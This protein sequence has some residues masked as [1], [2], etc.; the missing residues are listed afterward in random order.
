M[1][2]VTIQCINIYVILLWLMIS[3]RLWFSCVNFKPVFYCGQ[4]PICGFDLN[5]FA[6]Q[7]F[8]LQMNSISSSTVSILLFHKSLYSFVVECK[9][10][11]NYSTLSVLLDT[12]HVSMT[13]YLCCDR[14][15]SFNLR[16]E[17]GPPLF[18]LH[19]MVYV[20]LE[21]ETNREI[22]QTYHVAVSISV[23]PC[24]N[25]LINHYFF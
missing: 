11:L 17:F 23:C 19:N 8:T 14:I 9:Q 6:V 4:G 13:F 15:I 20:G 24:V 22:C 16:C 18:C 25:N 1:V 2:Y 10:H 12:G 7:I 21:T 5:L 3:E